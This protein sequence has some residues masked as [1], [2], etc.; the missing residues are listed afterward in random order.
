MIIRTHCLGRSKTLSYVWKRNHKN[1]RHLCLV[2]H[3]FI[4]LSQYVCLINMYISIYRFARCYCRLWKALDFIL[5]IAIHYWQTFLKCRY[6]HQ[7][8]TE[9]VSNQCTH[10]DLSTCQM[11]LQVMAVSFTKLRSLGIFITTSLKRYSFIKRVIIVRR[12]E[13]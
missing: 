4:K 10:F 12:D 3:I 7:I 2:A 8:F 13:K 9:C 5:G 1:E 11:W 6:L